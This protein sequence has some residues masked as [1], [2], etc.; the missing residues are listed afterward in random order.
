MRTLPRVL[1][2]ALLV[3]AVGG[4]GGDVTEEVTPTPTAEPSATTAP[5]PTT[6]PSPTAEPTP[7][8]TPSPS[9]TA[10]EQPAIWPAP[11]VVFDDPETAAADFVATVLGVPPN[12]GDFQQGDTR[13]GEIE[14][15]PPPEAS[16]APVRSLLLLRQL[17]PDD[18]WFVLAAISGTNTIT[19]P[20]SGSTVTAGPIEVS[21]EGRGF[22]G[23]LVVEARVVGQA[24]QLD[25]QLA[26]GGSM[27]D[28]EP[29]TVTVD[30]SGASSGDTVL[31]L[32]RGG[33]G[34]ETDPGEFSAISLVIG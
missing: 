7:T 11:D 31:V 14:V 26:Q 25:E 3:A 32:V 19:T 13:S 9:V 33:V 1:V 29:Y 5:S 12:L 17:G 18:G 23:L 16:G 4:C 30:L 21:G 27:E 2:A 24:T 28:V 10:L 34:L 6:E 20:P 22:E 15:L 8:P